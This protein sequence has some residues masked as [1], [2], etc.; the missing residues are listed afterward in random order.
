MEKMNA[1]GTD[2]GR[3]VMDLR[4]PFT[5]VEVD[6]TDVDKICDAYLEVKQEIEKLRAF[7]YA[8]RFRLEAMTDSD[9]KTRR[10]FGDKYE[11]KLTMPDDYWSQTTFKECVK[12]FPQ[13][14]ETYLRISAYAPNLKEVK[15][16]E[17]ASGSEE[18]M[19]F[20]SLLLSGRSESN[21]PASV[22]IS[23]AKK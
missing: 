18:F 19:R 9:A 4:H 14:S 15:K 5:W 11:V 12:Q 23:E 8:L 7:E 13:M 16:L 22:S 10:V 2:L 21:S 1:T 3:A 20:K 17:N 6:S